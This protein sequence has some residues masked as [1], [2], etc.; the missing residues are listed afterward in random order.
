MK[1]TSDGVWT[2]NKNHLRI[3]ETAE[4]LSYTH[5]LISI[6]SLKNKSNIK[7]NF[8]EHVFDL[9]KLKFISYKDHMYKLT[10][11]GLDC[12]AINALRKKGLQ[13]MGSNIG[14]GKESDIYFGKF[15]NQKAAIK[16]HRLGRSCFQ[17]IEERNLKDDRN[18]FTLNKE[19]CRDE[20]K[21]LN[22]FKNLSIPKLYDYDRHAIVMEMLDYDTLYK[23]KVENPEVISAKMIMLIKQIYDLGYVH[24]DFNE[25]NIMVLGDDVKVIDFP[26]CIPTTDP[27]AAFYLKRDI[28]CVHKFFW[29]KNFFEV[30]HSIL[31]DIIIKHDIKIEI[32]KKRI[33]NEE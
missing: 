12:L 7:G 28:E 14:I 29:K 26:Q 5:D 25:F 4:R 32:D 22:L 15:N 33:I 13:I 24:G 30:D 31:N 3:L 6:D 1:L 2:V 19:S 11:S 17:K 27:K 18:W 8:Q 9:V 21:F 23:I 16:I 10:I 20:V